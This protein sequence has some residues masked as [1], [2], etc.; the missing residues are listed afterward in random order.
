[1]NNAKSPDILVVGDPVDLVTSDLGSSF[2]IAASA[3]CGKT[4]ILIARVISLIK[5]GIG[6]ERLLL[7]TFTENAAR[8]RMISILHQAHGNYFLINITIGR[9]AIAITFIL[10]FHM[11]WGYPERECLTWSS[12]FKYL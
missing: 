12:H 9:I 7:L 3:G 6:I 4:H 5:K 11:H 10:L 1:M 2:S 8:L